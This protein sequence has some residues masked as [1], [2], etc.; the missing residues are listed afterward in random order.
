MTKSIK[1]MWS[2]AGLI[3]VL[4]MTRNVGPGNV[5]TLNNLMGSESV[6]VEL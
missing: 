3:Y 4:H 1:N 6:D 5:V 2:N